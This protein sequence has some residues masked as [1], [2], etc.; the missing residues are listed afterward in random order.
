MLGY[1][2]KIVVTKNLSLHF[3]QYSKLFTALKR[4]LKKRTLERLRFRMN[5]FRLTPVPKHAVKARMGKGKGRLD[6]YA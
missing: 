4:A 5:Q 3:V 6:S 1:L 2:L